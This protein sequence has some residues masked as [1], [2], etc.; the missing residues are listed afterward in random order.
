M[1]REEEMRKR[2]VDMM[3]RSLAVQEQTQDKV[4]DPIQNAVNVMPP[5]VWQAIVTHNL[6]NVKDMRSR[7]PNDMRPIIEYLMGRQEGQDEDLM[8]MRPGDEGAM[9]QARLDALQG[10]MSAV[11]QNAHTESPEQAAGRLRG[12]LGKHKGLKE[13]LEDFWDDLLDF[14]GNVIATILPL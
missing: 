2:W 8:R 12:I 13:K 6:Q 1:G 7:N 9:A 4:P 5:E 10:V 3:K 14:T 11:A